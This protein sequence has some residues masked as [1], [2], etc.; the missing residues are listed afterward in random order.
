MATYAHNKKVSF[1][2]EILEKFEAGIELLG[3]EVKSVK[4]KHGHLDGAR[5]L[6]RG[7][8]A[9]LVGASIPPYQPQNTPSWYEQDRNRK[10]LLTKKE[11]VDLAQ[12]EGKKGLTI[13]PVSLYQKGKKIKIEIAVVRGKKKYDK[14]EAIKKRDTERDIAREYKAS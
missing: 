14:R 4:E 8:E 5:V 2:Y 10:L 13:V 9:F 7:G 3:L 12:I 11:L 6:V 1:D